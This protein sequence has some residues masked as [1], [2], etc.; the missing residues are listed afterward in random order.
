MAR[1][2]ITF[3]RSTATGQSG[4]VIP[5][6]NLTSAVTEVVTSSGTSSVTTTVSPFGGNAGL[7]TIYSSG[8]VWV[9]SGPPAGLT[10]AV[11]ASGATSPGQR[12]EA[13]TSISFSVNQG[14]AVAVIDIV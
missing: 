8:E 5:V 9:V 10:A 1:V 7:V 14:D 12:V 4:G 2:E 11:P 3:C 13:T 6:S